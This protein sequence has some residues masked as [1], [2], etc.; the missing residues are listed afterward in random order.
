MM[1][2]NPVD[3]SF[4]KLIQK[5]QVDYIYGFRD[6]EFI[7]KLGV[8]LKDENGEFKNTF[9]ILCEAFT[10]LVNSEVE[11]ECQT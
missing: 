1:Q 2:N 10:V 4:N 3:D 6:T 7:E 11:R 8:S 5:L 9:D